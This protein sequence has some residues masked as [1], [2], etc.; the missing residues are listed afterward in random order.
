[1][2][3]RKRSQNLLGRNVMY[4]PPMRYTLMGGSW[5]LRQITSY[6]KAVEWMVV[7]IGTAANGEPGMVKIATTTHQGEFNH[8]ISARLAWSLPEGSRKGEREFSIWLHRG[9]NDAPV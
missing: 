7:E 8:W 5:V 6:R 9:Y 2:A 3:I 4:R 1:M